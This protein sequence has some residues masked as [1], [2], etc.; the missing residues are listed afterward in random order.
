MNKKSKF[1]SIFFFAIALFG[2]FSFAKNVDA[3]TLTPVRFEL[4]ANPGETLSGEILLTNETVNTE[5]FYLS[6]SN[7]EAQGESGTPAF[8]KPDE[9]LG[10]WI[11]TEK[12]S[13]T[14]EAGKQELVPFKI[15]IPQNAE[16]GGHFAVVFFGTSRNDDSGTVGVGSQTGTLVLL[17]V[18]GDVKEDAGLL[19][20]FTKD[21]VFW[22]KTLPVSFEYRFRNDG[23]DR[24]KP[25][26]EIVLRNTLFLPTERL[27]ANKVEG[28]VLP[29]S[30]R[31]FKVDWI[32]F[33]RPIDY[34]V[35]EGVF[36]KFWDNVVYEWKNF[37]LGLYSANLNIDFGTNGEKANKTVF[38]F[39][40]PWELTIVL[41]IAILIIFFG[42][43][44]A[45]RR[46]NNYIIKKARESNKIAS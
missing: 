38:F 33:E 10:T 45:L 29:G 23:G 40:F 1:I 14:V 20:F 36:N 13:F 18:K 22:Y 43:K 44:A 21:K 31:K 27:D 12:D 28:N 24:V 19:D 3:V 37:A 35:P 7:F 25:Q 32:N 5:T 17:S 8:V 41:I 30:T 4:S 34:I 39:V 46:Y 26:G 42:G 9:G 2:V 15:N 11:Q 16:P 6:Y